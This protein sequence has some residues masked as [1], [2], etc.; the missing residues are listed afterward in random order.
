[1]KEAL[2]EAKLAYE[3]GEVPIGCVIVSGGEIIGRGHNVREELRDP[4]AH[5]EMVAIGEAVAKMPSW[6]VEDATCYVTVEP[7]PMCM[8]AIL[9]ARIDR[10]VLGT[11]NDNF[12][13]AGS[14]VDLPALGAFQHHIQVTKGVL[15]EECRHLMQSFFRSLRK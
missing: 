1:M 15:E 4:R 10:L 6:R 3:K 5:G 8:G 13:A 9:N 14:V 11:G 7:C 12:G 2:K